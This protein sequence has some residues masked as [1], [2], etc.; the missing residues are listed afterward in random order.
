MAVSWMTWFWENEKFCA[1]LGLDGAGKT[2]LVQ[3]I[4]DGDVSETVPTMGFTVDTLTLHGAN[5]QLAD[6]CGQD[7]M[8]VIWLSFFHSADAIIYVVDGTDRERLGVAIEELERVLL[9]PS[10]RGKPLLLLCNKQDMGAMDVKD[11]K[12]DV[13]H[14]IWRGFNVSVKTGENVDDALLWLIRN[15]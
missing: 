6:V 5:V 8:R 9:Y 14:D 10:T 15:L 1:V 11:I 12:F 2:A 13:P 4:R 7:A 3:R